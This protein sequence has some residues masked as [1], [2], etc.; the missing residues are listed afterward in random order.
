M[1]QHES[2]HPLFQSFPFKLHSNSL[3]LNLA[4]KTI[5]R[6]FMCEAPRRDTLGKSASYLGLFN[7]SKNIR[8]VH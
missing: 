7:N 3:R 8:T 4:T 1:A 5:L 6:G 2:I